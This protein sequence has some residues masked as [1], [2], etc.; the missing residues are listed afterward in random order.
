MNQLNIFYDHVL[1]AIRQNPGMSADKIL[2]LVHSYGYSGLECDYDCLAGHPELKECFDRHNLSVVSIYCRFNFPDKSLISSLSRIHGLIKTAKFYGTHNILIIPGYTK[3]PVTVNNESTDLFTEF[4]CKETKKM[5]TALK[6]I[7]KASKN[8]NINITLEDYDDEFAPYSTDKGLLF[9]IKNVPGLKLTFDTGNFA[10]S[11]IDESAAFEKLKSQITHAHLKDRSFDSSRAN[12]QNNNGKPDLSGKI[13]YP[14]E[15]CEGT[16]K[17]T[18]IIN[19]LL[20]SG[21]TGS[22]SVEHFGAVNQLE[23]MEKSAKAII[24]LLKSHKA[25][26]EET[27]D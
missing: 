13:M 5:I 11:L 23:Y 17:I 21:Y 15:V 27:I 4:E 3:S 6:Y 24:N 22:F 18:E 20:D 16:I 9:F 26:C 7:V 19:A 10:Y 2:N 1:E 8:Q 14:C 12:S 25:E